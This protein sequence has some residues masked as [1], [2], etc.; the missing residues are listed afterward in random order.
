[1]AELADALDLGSS[2]AIRVT[3]IIQ[4]W[5]GT[6]QKMFS[7]GYFYLLNQTVKSNHFA[8]LYYK[9]LILGRVGCNNHKTAARERTI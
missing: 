8:L 6:L 4:N 1:M 9:K 3:H 5:T 7:A 2:E